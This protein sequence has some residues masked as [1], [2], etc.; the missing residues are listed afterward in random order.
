MGWDIGF[1]AIPLR[2]GMG[3]FPSVGWDIRGTLAWDGFSARYPKGGQ[4]NI[5]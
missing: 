5:K 3:R 2:D 1:P 4:D